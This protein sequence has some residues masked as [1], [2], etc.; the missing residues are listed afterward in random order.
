VV[1]V[2]GVR[3]IK[4]LLGSDS[5]KSYTFGQE[6]DNATEFTFFPGANL[7]KSN[8]AATQLDVNHRYKT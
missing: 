4:G 5:Y 3:A 1:V 2:S 6:I 8:M 7:A